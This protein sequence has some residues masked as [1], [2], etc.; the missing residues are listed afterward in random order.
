MTSRTPAVPLKTPIG[1]IAA[2][3]ATIALLVPAAAS[4]VGATTIYACVNKKSGAMR[5]VS[6]KAKCK[7]TE[8]KLSWGA[9]GPAGLPGKEGKQGATGAPG[10][11][12]VGIDYASSSFGPN[13]LP[14]GE[15]GEIVVSE[16]IPA[17]SYFVS[18]KTI[19]GGSE[20]KSAV[21]V[22]TICE[23]VDSASTPRLVE[24]N[25]AIDVGE[26][27]QTLSEA[28]AKDWVAAG[29]M[30]L[31]GQLTTTQ[32]TTLALDCLAPEGAKEAKVEAVASQ[33]SALQTTKNE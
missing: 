8:R 10:S 30:S 1:A 7:R 11:N 20:A 33:V 26:W 18:A 13:V 2:L 9:T 24:L 25:E 31:Q 3:V 12:G 22:A 27:A 29:T 6:A 5:I 15:T 23:L 21:F 19:I 32:P 4:A 14:G 28:A 17:G 16:T